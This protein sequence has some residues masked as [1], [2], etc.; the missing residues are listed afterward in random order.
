MS[1]KISQ[2][3]KILSVDASGVLTVVQ[4]GQ[5]FQIAQEDYF[6]Q[7]G[8]TGSLVQEGDPTGT[9]VL[10]P[11]GTVN[12]I[13]NLEDGS[14]V[15]SSV[16][17]QNGITLDHNFTVDEVGAPLMLN[18]TLPSPTF[19]SLLGSASIAVEQV[20]NQIKFDLTGEAVSTK[21]VVVNQMS[22]FPTA[23]GGVI[24]LVADTDYLITNDLTT[25]DRFTMEDSSQ[26]RAAGTVIITLA[27]T[28]TGAMFSC[29]DCDIRFRNI[30]LTAMSG[31]L[32]NATSS[33]GAAVGVVSAGSVIFIAATGGNISTNIFSLNSCAVILFVDGFTSTATTADIFSV[34]SCTWIQSAGT[35]VDF[36]TTV[37][38]TAQADNMF[39]TLSSGVT[40]I[41][42]AANS[43]NI[44]AT[45]EGL[46]T[47]LRM[48][49]DGSL[50]TTID[51]DDDRWFLFGNSGD[52]NARDTI[53]DGISSMQGNST[54][55]VIAIIGTPV[56]VAGTFVVG[57]SS[58]FTP[59]TTGR[60]TYDLLNTVI[61]PISVSMAVQMATGGSD[62]VKAC[63]A[64][65]GT[66]V[67]E[68]CIRT[69]VNASG[70]GNIFLTWQEELTQNDFIEVFVQN[71][72]DTTNII[73]LDMIVR[74]N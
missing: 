57:R 56:K 50:I 8:T 11:Q 22:D 71:D 54:E 55:T 68:S 21:T 73:V 27:Y 10:D 15:K 61:T 44:A 9:P 69:I 14:G 62:T 39:L 38:Q 45:G 18:K 24:P 25:A 20:G 43:A 42:G 65:N 6:K 32:F 19:P 51:A 46:L 5:N 12:N 47:R 13:R 33:T 41:D 16:S 37:F 28:G 60:V 23:V 64:I 66:V 4:N 74:V 35:G 72:T 40:F 70:A 26:I 1:T 58:G 63:V 49:G 7:F 52:P 59:D 31:S 34:T 48:T 17:A 67:P 3:I 53:R 30:R 2:M 36:G 29:Q